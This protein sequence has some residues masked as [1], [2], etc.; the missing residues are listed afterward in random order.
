MR[1]ITVGTGTA[2]PSPHRVQS[3]HLVH[4]GATTLLMDCGS[5]IAHRMAALGIAW[6]DVTHVALSHFHADHTIDIATLMYA[7]RYGQLPPRAAPL[8]VIG[9]PGTIALLDQMA[10]TFGATVRDPG[11]ALEVRELAS[12]ERA[13]MGDVALEARKVPHT[14]E[15]VAYSVEHEGRRLVYTG[16]TA[17]D[18]S[19]A[20]WA[21]GCDL[22][23][24]EC[25]LPDAL[26]VPTH[27]TPRQCGALAERAAPGTLLLTHF[28]P[29]VEHVDIRAEVR[30]RFP[31]TVELAHDGWS[32]M[33]GG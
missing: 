3:G 15:S 17:Y 11:F 29:P 22:L 1:L 27:L 6:Q 31:G 24:M 33:V 25:S 12:G 10:A 13:M 14:D 9:P 2:A 8:T 26:A 4:A 5:G 30:E 7:W 16:D 19:L 21:E 32:C 23:L 28:Y 20:E 18:E